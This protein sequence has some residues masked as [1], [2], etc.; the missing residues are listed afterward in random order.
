MEAAKG[1]DW[2]AGLELSARRF[3]EE[4]SERR[5]VKHEGGVEV[6]FAKMD[7]DQLDAEILKTLD[8]EIEKPEGSE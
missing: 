1:G 6:R 7:N 4:Y 2:R 5:V 3:P 8:A